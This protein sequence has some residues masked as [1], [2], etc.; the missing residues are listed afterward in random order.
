MSIMGFGLNSVS[1]RNLVPVPP[2]RIMVGM[3]LFDVFIYFIL[4]Y[5]DRPL[6]IPLRN[7]L[8]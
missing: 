2:Q 8:L 5:L 3:L 6:Q 4:Y 7:A 1:S